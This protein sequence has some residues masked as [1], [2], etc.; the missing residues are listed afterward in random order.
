MEDLEPVV[1]SACCII[2]PRAVWEPIQ[3]IRQDHDPAFTR[4]PPHANLLYPF[5]ADEHF[6]VVAERLAQELADCGPLTVT[7]AEFGYFRHSQRSVT[8][9]LRPDISPA[10]A[11]DA[12]WDRLERAFPQCRRKDGGRQAHLSVAKAKPRNDR[13][14]DKLVASF[15]AGWEPI[16]FE[17]DRLSIISR[18]GFEDPFHERFH[19]LLGKG[20]A[21]PAVDALPYQVTAPRGSPADLK[22]NKGKGKAGDAGGKGNS[23]GGAKAPSKAPKTWPALRYADGAWQPH[24]DANNATQLDTLRIVSQNVL[25]DK[26]DAHLIHSAARHPA[27]LRELRERNADVILLQEMTS[28]TLQMV[29]DC[30]WIRRDYFVSAGRPDHGTVIPFGQVTLARFPFT[31]SPRRFS[32]TKTVLLAHATLSGRHTVI[33]NVHLTS[34][35]ESVDV[36]RSQQEQ[37]CAWIAELRSRRGAAPI[38]FVLAGDFN[39]F[40]DEPVGLPEDFSEITGALPNTFDPVRNGMAK[41]TSRSGLQRRLDRVYVVFA[42]GSPWHVE[43]V[44]MV[45]TEPVVPLDDG[46]E[47]IHVSDH[48]GVLTV[49]TTAPPAL[50]NVD[51]LARTGAQSHEIAAAFVEALV[52]EGIEVSLIGSRA[53][54][55]VDGDEPATDVDFVLTGTEARSSLF[56]RM[57][58]ALRSS[59]HAREVRVVDAVVPLVSF[60]L[61][62]EGRRSPI[63]VEVQY[64]D[65]TGADRTPADDASAKS[66]AA[67]G[68]ADMV[69]RAVPDAKQFKEVLLQLRAWAK[70]RGIYGSATGFPSGLAWSIMAARALQDG[71]EARLA[72]VLAHLAAWDF[73]AQPLSLHGA[74]DVGANF[75]QGDRD[76]MPVLGGSV[77]ALVNVTRSMTASTAAIVRH[78]LQGDDATYS[79]ER[80]HSFVTLR[81][82]SRGEAGH[83]KA[84]LVGVMLRVEGSDY[85]VVPVDVQPRAVILAVFGR[86]G[87][88]DFDAVAER[89]GAALQAVQLTSI[90]LE[91]STERPEADSSSSDGEDGDGDG[92]GNGPR[93]GERFQQSNLED[94]KGKKTKKQRMRTSIEVYNRILWDPELNAADFM[95]GYE[96]RFEGIM[97]APVPEFELDVIPFHRVRIFRHIPSGA[98]VWDR[99]KRYDALFSYGA[100]RVKGSK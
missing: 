55:I 82:R 89:V 65:L 1:K 30:D 34:G 57:R 5:V 90:R 28:D 77:D 19:V 93:A 71:A 3:R 98:V 46:A 95:V 70:M 9:W 86:S 6:P 47:P 85:V 76:A 26:Y 27:L 4:W 8:V 83:L 49:L 21:A 16:V 7:L 81:A 94:Q 66:F 69:R 44:S 63:A 36:R 24:P 10:G 20:Q 53:L 18:A 38:D 13:E 84:R 25:F 35:S 56:D 11:L 17:I 14:V 60:D 23:R 58:L 42:P 54:G 39:M 96:D 73:V 37:L 31:C 67:L 2:P 78:R 40:N 48:F 22:F 15:R 51:A 50:G 88:V 52:G 92:N 12:I 79:A 62:V 99:A 68:D 29:L 72:P 45:H 64:A 74:Q 91:C 32:Q 41:V 33:A 75:A 97:E 100:H 59:P 61:V 87:P 80:C 43:T